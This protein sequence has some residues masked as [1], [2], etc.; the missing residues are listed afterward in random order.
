[1][2]FKETSSRN[3]VMYARVCVCGKPSLS[4]TEWEQHSPKVIDVS[5]DRDARSLATIT[6]LRTLGLEL[7]T[8]LTGQRLGLRISSRIIKCSCGFRY[9]IEY[10]YSMPQYIYHSH[11]NILIDVR[12][13]CTV[14][15]LEIVVSALSVLRYVTLYLCSEC[16]T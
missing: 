4:Q 14:E 10:T 5:V 13:S 16:I 3:S 1:M 12:I 2:W 7:R 6:W 15:R 11:T 8:N 9:S